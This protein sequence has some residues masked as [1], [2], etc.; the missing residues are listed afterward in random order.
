MPGS[1]IFTDKVA[2]TMM[3]LLKNKLGILK[4][5]SFDYEREFNT[6]EPVGD[7]VRIK[8]PW[9]AT[10][11]DGFGWQANSI[12]RRNRTV[13]M[14]QP[15]SVQFL[16]DSIE[17]AL[18][19]ERTF[20]DVEDN[21][22]DPAMAQLSQECE[23]RAALFAYRNTPNVIGALGVTP[24]TLDTYNAAKTRISELGGW[25]PGTAKRGMFISPQME[26]TAITGTAR[27]LFNPTTVINKAFTD[28]VIGFYGGFEWMASASLYQHTS[29]IF[30]TVLTGTTVSGAGQSGSSINLA[31]TTGD[32]LLVGDKITFALV[33]AVNRRTRRST[34]RLRAFT[35]TVSVTFAASAATVSIFP[36]IVG[37]GSAYQNVTALPANAAIVLQWPGTTMVDATATTG[38]VGL[39]FTKDA[40]ACVGA[41]LPMPKK[42]TKQIA[43]Q[44]TDKATGI[45]ISYIQ[46]FITKERETI[47]RMD[48]LMGFGNMWAEDCAVA[49]AGL[50]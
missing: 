44:Y 42:G 18:E 23:S 26:E 14:D 5:F 30:T 15:F 32:T 24:T 9:A 20:E 28:G 27:G 8:E 43:E 31:G 7:T 34:G 48:V 33:N 10:V 47:N 39:A 37:P 1:H 11:Q 13:A 19:M 46:D 41:K 17:Q 25:V 16:W 12:I 4:I 38:V 3:R 45:S 21:I 6:D 2:P 36:Q 49:I 35:V 50:R 40:F 29:G 22:I